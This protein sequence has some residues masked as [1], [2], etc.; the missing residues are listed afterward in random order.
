MRVVL[1]LLLALAF[2][3][4]G[5]RSSSSSGFDELTE[6][7]TKMLVENARTI[8]VRDGKTEGLTLDEKIK[9]V[10][11]MKNK[12]GKDDK[13]SAKIS[14]RSFSLE[15]KMIVKK[16]E[17]QIRCY[18]TGDK[19]GR[20]TVSWQLSDTRRVTFIAKGKLLEKEKTWEMSVVNSEDLVVTPEARK[21]LEKSG[22]TLIQDLK[23]GKSFPAGQ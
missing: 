12:K 8:F 15:D 1:L 16:T 21:A 22:S 18:Y 13:T 7:E 5:C 10:E 19:E 11:A 2:I 20:V 9:A 6:D 4:A 17:P 23:A 14:T 3:P